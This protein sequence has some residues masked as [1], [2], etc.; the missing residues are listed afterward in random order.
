[1][2]RDFTKQISLLVVGAMILSGLGLVG[3]GNL[4]GV[5][6]SQVE[7]SSILDADIVPI[8]TS[9]NEESIMGDQTASN[10]YYKLDPR[11]TPSVLT[12]Q[13]DIV[14]IYV[15]TY[16]VAELARAL[17]GVSYSGGIG[18]KASGN[19]FAMPYLEISSKDIP[20]ILALDSVVGVYQ[21]DQPIPGWK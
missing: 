5:S 11:L 1:M 2:Q 18:T 10:P 14:K 20:K 17:E 16:D 6:E 15:A 12:G 8:S 4:A 13:K 3:I 7:R 9:V 19:N 21:Y